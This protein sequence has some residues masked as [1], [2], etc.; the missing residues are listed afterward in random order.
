MYTY[1]V[2]QKWVN[3]RVRSSGQ[4]NLDYSTVIMKRYKRFHVREIDSAAFYATQ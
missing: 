4:I 1:Y 3:Y 2:A